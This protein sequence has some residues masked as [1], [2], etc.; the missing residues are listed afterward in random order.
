MILLC[1][2]LIT[3][4]SKED[5]K[6]IDK[7]CQV[8]WMVANE[9]LVHMV[10]KNDIFVYAKDYPQGNQFQYGYTVV[11]NNQGLTWACAVY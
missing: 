2:G 6:N 7:E 3:W 9:I 11:Y 10:L 5:L 8:V 4:Y 1:S